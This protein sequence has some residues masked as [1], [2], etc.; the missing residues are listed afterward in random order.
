[1]VGEVAIHGNCDILSLLIKEIGG[2]VREVVEG[3]INVIGEEE[4]V[5]DVHNM[6]YLW[7]IQEISK[8]I[9]EGEVVKKWRCLSILDIVNIGEV[10]EGEVF[11]KWRCLLILD[12]IN[13]GEV[14]EG[15]VDVKDAVS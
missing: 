13:N 5:L 3:S 12:I 7:I 11:K 6:I 2:I 8:Q 1:M 4:V 9:G 15:E 10:G 14:G